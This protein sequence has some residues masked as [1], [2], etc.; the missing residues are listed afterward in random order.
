MDF[1]R[2]SSMKRGGELQKFM[3]RV[4]GGGGGG[5][6]TNTRMTIEKQCLITKHTNLC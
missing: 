3:V 5:G 4:G 6:A 2:V 1:K